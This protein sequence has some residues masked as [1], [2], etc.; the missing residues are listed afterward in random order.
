MQTIKLTYTLELEV[1]ADALLSDGDL[2]VREVRRM[3]QWN[4]ARGWKAS[5]RRL[6]GVDRGH[7]A[8]VRT[9]QD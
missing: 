2:Y 3:L 8:L 1:P 9:P 6:I 7:A 5:L 4:Q